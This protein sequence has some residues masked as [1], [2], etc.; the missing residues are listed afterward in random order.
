MRIIVATALT[1][2]LATVGCSSSRCGQN[3]SQQ[4]TY[5]VGPQ[6]AGAPVAPPPPAPPPPPAAAPVVTQ[7]SNP[8]NDDF[9][10]SSTNTARDARSR[11]Y[12]H[13]E[14]YRWLVGR[15]Q[16]VHVPGSDW[17]LRY[18]PLSAQDQYGGSVVLSLDARVDEFNDGDVVYMEGEIIGNRPTLYLSGPLYRIGTIQAVPEHN[19]IASEPKTRQ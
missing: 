6:C 14:D 7:I 18:L 10:G 4:C 11:G 3:G 12:G 1:A 9:Q 13:A 2:A 16:R 17:K 5:S 15:L 8:P 19:R